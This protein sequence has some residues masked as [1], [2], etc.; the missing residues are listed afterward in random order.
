MR[1]CTVVYIHVWPLGQHLKW[2]GI[3]YSQQCVG[4]KLTGTLP[5]PTLFSILFP[6]KHALLSWGR[7]IKCTKVPTLEELHMYL[8]VCIQMWILSELPR[9]FTITWSIVHTCFTSP[10]LFVGSEA[11]HIKHSIEQDRLQF[12]VKLHKPLTTVCYHCASHTLI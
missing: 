11:S 7:T 1:E 12:I 9:S 8:S 3:K 6:C 10:Q 2:R 5:N 4:S